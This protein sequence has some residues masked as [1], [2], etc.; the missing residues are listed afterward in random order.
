MNSYENKPNDYSFKHQAVK[1]QYHFSK[2]FQQTG[3]TAS[4]G[5]SESIFEIPTR[6]VNFGRSLLKFTLTPGAG[7]HY[8]YLQCDTLPIEQI[9]LYTRGRKNGLL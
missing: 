6:C 7:T 1:N 3:G 4:A 8:N 2:L 9:Q 5:G